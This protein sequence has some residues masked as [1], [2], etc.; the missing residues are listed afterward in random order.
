MST[1]PYT[2][3]YGAEGTTKIPGGSQYARAALLA[4]Q[5][6]KQRLSDLNRQRQQTMISSGYTGNIDP[7]TGLLKDF[8][9]DPTSKYGGY[10]LLN[11]GQ[12]QQ[13]QEVTAQNIDR[14]L[15]TGGGLAAQN[16]GNARFEWGRQ[17]ADFARG[18][19]DQF[20]AFDRTQMDYM[21]DRDQAL[22]NAELQAAQSAIGAGD[23]GSPGGGDDWYDDD[24]S[25]AQEP[26]LPPVGRQA[27]LLP[28]GVVRNA[29]RKT[30]A[31][32]KRRPARR[33]QVVATQRWAGGKKANVVNTR[34]VKRKKKKPVPGKYRAWGPR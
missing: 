20:S 21:F 1:T 7:T 30:F 12:Y 29:I 17:D 11:R 24:P 27:P 5:Q 23:Y 16:L 31:P 6:Y 2:S 19:Q 22:Y 9:V 3:P 18:I 25:G 13:G 32:K 8:R 10:Q 33:K 26:G 28:A 34:P 4:N 15:G 14:G